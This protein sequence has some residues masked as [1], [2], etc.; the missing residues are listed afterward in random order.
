LVELAQ[1]LLTSTA[2]A[3]SANANANANR[4]E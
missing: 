2:S 4:I 1:S 3:A